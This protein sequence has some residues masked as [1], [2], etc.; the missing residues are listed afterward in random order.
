M[1]SQSK[2]MVPSEVNTGK[3]PLIEVL[4]DDLIDTVRSDAVRD[5]LIKVREGVLDI[6]A[7]FI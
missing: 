5:A 2:D 4:P 6:D 7:P 3:L 1:T